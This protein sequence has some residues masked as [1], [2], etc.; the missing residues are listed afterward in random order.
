MRYPVL[1]FLPLLL[2][3]CNRDDDQIINN[4]TSD[5]IS[6]YLNIDLQQLANYSSYEYPIHIDQNTFN[7]F[8]NTPI[9][10]PVTDEGATLGRV[11]F[12]DKALSINN[13]I[14]CASCHNQSV[15]FSDTPAFSE[16]FEGGFTTAH[17]MRLVN[18]RYYAGAAM[19]WD[20]R[21]ASLEE[22][23]TQ[24]IQHPVEMGFDAA[25]GGMDSLIRKL[26]DIPYYPELFEFVF[27]SPIV[28]EE[29]IQLALAQFIR[30]IES[31]QSRFDEGFAQVFNPALPNANVGAD[32]PNYTAEENL[33]KM[34]FLTPPPAGGAGCAGCHTIPTF[35][36]DANSLSNGLD[37][38]ET[39]IF[40][41]PSLKNVGLESHFMHDGRFSSLEEVIDH[42]DSGIQDGPALDN[43]LRGPGGIPQQLNLTAEE[44]A[45]LKAFLLTLNDAAVLNTVA[46]SD[47]F[48]P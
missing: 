28:T 46:F 40:K 43:R 25:N 39:T 44:K 21:A 38:G 1:F 27:G 20:K 5:N 14:A 15:G 10:N 23:S 36:L 16:G 6:D 37:A 12:Y 34:L 45:A 13:T 48:L 7:T 29:N 11:L 2:L 9:A 32:F 4:P 24:P 33:G 41:A 17:S 30:S 19:F 26:Q 35:S 18:T 8:D 42:Y 3:G 47:P 22:Q 31:Y